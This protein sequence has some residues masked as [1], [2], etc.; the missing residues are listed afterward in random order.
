MSVV[1]SIDS[2]CS[3]QNLKTRTYA[4]DEAPYRLKDPQTHSPGS[5]NTEA[6]RK[7]KQQHQDLD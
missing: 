2:D 3:K 5:E 7:N 4:L 1:G 6:R